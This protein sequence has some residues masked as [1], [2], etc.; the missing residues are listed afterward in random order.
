[1]NTET[2][3]ETVAR[4][5]AQANRLRQ[6]V[7]DLTWVGQCGHPGGSLSLAEILACL[8][9]EVLRIDPQ[10][11]DWVDRDRLVLSKG[12]A[13]PIYYAALAEC[14]YF[15]ADLLSTYGRVN[16]ILQGHPDMGTP[17]VDMSSGSLGQG[18]STGVG[19]A[20]G[21]KIKK[22]HFHT[23]VIIG[24]GESQEGQVWEAALVAPRFG[25]DN[26]T[27]IVDKNRLQLVDLTDNVIPLEPFADKWRAFNWHV[28]EVD[29]HNVPQLLS[30][31]AEAKQTKGRPT[32]IVAHTV[33]GKGVSFMEEQVCW[34]SR[35]P[36][37]SEYTL[38]M[39]ELELACKL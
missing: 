33:K 17:G 23:Y 27:V 21:A 7:I 11:P 4:L 18:L 28:V 19:M 8:Y 20:L 29:G 38:A 16:T 3:S 22:R 32:A 12:H 10:Q 37:E 36:N 6:L 15:S 34:H 35:A 9:F 25:L 5:E 31:L 24:D 30:A 13:A 14:G 26:L 39:K 1:M 2:V